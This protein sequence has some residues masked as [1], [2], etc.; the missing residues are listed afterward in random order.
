MSP[1]EQVL[2]PTPFS[3]SSL[4]RNCLKFTITFFCSRK[5]NKIHFHIKRPSLTSP[6]LELCAVQLAGLPLVSCWEICFED[7]SLSQ[8]L[9]FQLYASFAF[10][11][12][13]DL[14]LT[15]PARS[16]MQWSFRE[17]FMSLGAAWSQTLLCHNFFA[18]YQSFYN[19]VIKRYWHCHVFGLQINIKL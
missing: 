18:S 12:A 4:S 9:A 14:R 1:S 7:S 6:L 16:A 2:L 3:C 10:S 8:C 5:K 15:L 17:S 11:L 19:L 13:R